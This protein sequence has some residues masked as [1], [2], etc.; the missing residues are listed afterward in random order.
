MSKASISPDES[1]NLKK[2]F[3][4]KRNKENHNLRMDKSFMANHKTMDPGKM[5]NQFSSI[6]A[7]T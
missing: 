5:I 1:L 4:C 7:I 3:K 6:M 2:S